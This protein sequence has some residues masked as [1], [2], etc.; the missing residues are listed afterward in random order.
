MSQFKIK[1]SHMF[2]THKNVPARANPESAVHRPCLRKDR[3]RAGMSRSGT[4]RATQHGWSS[5]AASGAASWVAEKCR[6]SVN[7]VWLFWWN[8]GTRTIC[9]KRTMSIQ[10]FRRPTKSARFFTILPIPRHA[11]P[12]RDQATCCWSS[13]ICVAW[14]SE[15]ETIS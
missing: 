3:K 10:M 5:S 2:G 4:S 6:L 13:S 7:Q 15:K 12:S 11:T 1:T 14:D 8:G 9:Q